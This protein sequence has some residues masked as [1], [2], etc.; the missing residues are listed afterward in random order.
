MQYGGFGAYNR[1]N[2]GSDDAYD[3]ANC[4]AIIFDDMTDG[5]VIDLTV[6]DEGDESADAPTLQADQMGLTGLYI[7]SLWSSGLLQDAGWCGHLE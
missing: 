1:G 5:D 7:D 4:G 3:S 2:Q 6:T